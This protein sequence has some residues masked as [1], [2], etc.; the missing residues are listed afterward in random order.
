MF[1]YK[2]IARP[3]E[4]RYRGYIILGPRKAQKKIILHISSTPVTL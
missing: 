4:R 2:L 1:R 3:S